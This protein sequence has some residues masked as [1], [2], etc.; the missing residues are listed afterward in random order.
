LTTLKWMLCAKC[1]FSCIGMR[2]WILIYRHFCLIQ[3]LLVADHLIS[4]L[5]LLTYW[6]WLIDSRWLDSRKWP[7]KFYVLA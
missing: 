4:R 1:S 5:W 7:I 3:I 6:L 2:L